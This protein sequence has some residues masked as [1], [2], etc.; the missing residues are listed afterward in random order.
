MSDPSDPARPL[1]VPSGRLNRLGKISTMT[2][3]IAGNMALSGIA[4]LGQGQRPKMR[5][6]LL[7][8]SNITRVADQLAQMRG[9]AMKIGQLI[10]MDTGDLLPPEL[11]QIVARLRNDAHF[12]PP[13]QLKQVLNAGWPKDWLRAF[14][15]FDVHPIAA[16][17]IGQVHR[18]KLKDGRDM[19]IKVQY[20]GI[21]KSIDSD[22]ANVGALLRMSGLLPKGFE[23]APYLEQARAQLHDET[24]YAREGAQLAKFHTLLTDA[25][26]FEIPDL[27]ED[28]STP[29]ILAMRYL[30][31]IS[32]E[33]TPTKDRNQVVSDLIDLTLRELFEF[34]LMQTDP[35]FAN[36]LYNAQSHKIVLLDFGAA[37][38]LDPIIV[39]SYRCLMKAGLVG[40]MD[41]LR[42]ITAEIGFIDSDTKE[43][44][45]ER[46][47][48]MISRTFQAFAQTEIFDFAQNDL[49]RQM[50][51]EGTELAED[52]F[53][54]PPLPIDVL[55]LQRKLG[56]IFLLA[57]Q[58]KAQVN[59]AERMGKYLL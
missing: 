7:T 26:E 41:D 17:S 46:I 34:G 48:S 31:G 12:M 22:V 42:K 5:D 13:A 24:D 36:Y 47:L 51:L 37:R 35:N 32:I 53:I 11:S 16:A 52:G 40:D 4:Q 9:A 38:A 6:L 23:L 39:E 27:Y 58:L 8:P 49:S 45:R 28:W 59:V 18:A 55:L 10:S 43:H 25:P 20:P 14:E 29:N 50:Q 15:N 54:P 30:D 21:A 44:H 1:A 56:G 33:E 3:G 57:S 2:A 19:A